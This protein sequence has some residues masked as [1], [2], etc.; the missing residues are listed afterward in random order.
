[1]LGDQ[2]EVGSLGDVC[3]FIAAGIY[4]QP[5]AVPVYLPLQGG[6]FRSCAVLWTV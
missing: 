6:Q 3:L 4:I 1:M 5:Q 2:L